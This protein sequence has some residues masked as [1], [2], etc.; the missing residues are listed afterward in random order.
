MLH[1]TLCHDPLRAFRLHYKQNL[2]PFVERDGAIKVHNSI[3][4]GMLDSLAQQTCFA[5]K[6][7]ALIGGSRSMYQWLD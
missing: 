7:Q 2:Y 4:D 6:L 1:L 5:Y 3:Q